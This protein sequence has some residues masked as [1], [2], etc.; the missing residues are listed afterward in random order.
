MITGYQFFFPENL[1]LWEK[2]RET[3][4]K[5]IMLY[6]LEEPDGG[7]YYQNHKKAYTVSRITMKKSSLFCR[8]GAVWH[9]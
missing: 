6:L 9:Y 3:C 1:T 8:E 2:G 4:N 7:W 5:N